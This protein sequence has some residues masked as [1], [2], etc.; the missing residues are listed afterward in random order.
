MIDF[1][2]GYV[3]HIFVLCFGVC[4]LLMEIWLGNITLARIVSLQ[5]KRAKTS[6][7]MVEGATKELYV[8]DLEEV[9][10]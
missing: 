2:A 9:C 10:H 6:W 8:E 3:Y 4:F 7:N 1:F 5:N